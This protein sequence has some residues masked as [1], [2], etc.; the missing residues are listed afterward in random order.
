MAWRIPGGLAALGFLTALQ[1]GGAAQKRPPE[2]PPL[3]ELRQKLNKALGGHFE[4]TGDRLAR[5]R[6]DR[7]YWLV[8]LRA[9]RPGSYALRCD[10]RHDPVDTS[11]RYENTT[12]EFR[13]VVGPAGAARHH[14]HGLYA[15]MTSPEVCVGDTLVVPVPANRDDTDHRFTLTAKELAKEVARDWDQSWRMRGGKLD[16]R[17][18]AGQILKLLGSGIESHVT[19]DVRTKVHALHGLFEPLGPARCNLRFLVARGD[20]K[21]EEPSG[22]ISYPGTELAVEV[23]KRDQPVTVLVTNW[24][25]GSWT[26]ERTLG[27]SQEV[28]PGHYA[29][30]VG[31]RVLV[32]CGEQRV[33]A[34]PGAVRHPRVEVTR[35]AFAPGAEP[36]LVPGQK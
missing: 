29:L 28:R 20:K 5:D 24:G 3:A 32:Q 18:R 12:V 10:V 26:K 6:H 35:H 2:Q 17:N 22:S 36:F 27:S 4:M 7:R 21:G 31:D 14:Y 8:S 16:I 9:K 15:R 34:V 11:V 19:R 23:V 25:V 13:F 1:S 33:R 30:R